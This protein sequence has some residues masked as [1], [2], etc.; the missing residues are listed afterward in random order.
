MLGYIGRGLFITFCGSLFIG[1][2]FDIEMIIGI[3]I[4][5]IGFFNWVVRCKVG[6]NQIY[7]V[8]MDDYTKNYVPKDEHQSAGEMKK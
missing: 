6:R 5:I 3:I 8:D 7:E 2:D 4:I 1:D